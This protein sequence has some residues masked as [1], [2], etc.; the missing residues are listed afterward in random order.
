[1]PPRQ[2]SPTPTMTEPESPRE[3]TNP[4]TPTPAAG[5]LAA[6]LPGFRP[7]PDPP[8]PSP[9]PAPA[10]SRQE[11]GSDT[12]GAGDAGEPIGPELLEPEPTPA[13][14]TRFGGSFPRLS[15][16]LRRGSVDPETKALFAEFTG[17]LLEII[18][19][20]L[21]A[22]FAHPELYGPNSLWQPDASDH[23]HISQPAAS[24]IARRAPGGIQGDSDAADLLTM[25]LGAGGY[26]L[27]N[28]DAQMRLRRAMRAG[29]AFTDLEGPGAGGEP[30]GSTTAPADRIPGAVQ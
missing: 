7:P 19:G 14:R 11:M 13:P 15:L 29:G 28:T 12:A 2:S 23:R 20:L 10:S 27:K 17:K 26:A 24:I 16:S 30:T 6:D 8:A 22:R 4:T 21:Q 1:M 9:Q 18:G 3:P 5:D 25:T